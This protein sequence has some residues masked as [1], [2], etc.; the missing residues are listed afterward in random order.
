MSHTVLICGGYKHPHA[1]ESKIKLTTSKTVVL[2][3]LEIASREEQTQ[4]VP[5]SDEHTDSSVHEVAVR[6][7]FLFS[8]SLTLDGGW[9]NDHVG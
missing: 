3:T 4:D 6:G 8:R 5:S 9:C 1:I 2:G 7:V